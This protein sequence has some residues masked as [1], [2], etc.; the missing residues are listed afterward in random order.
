MLRVQMS[1][2]VKGECFKEAE[3]RTAEFGVVTVTPCNAAIKN[4]QKRI[5]SNPPPQWI[6]SRVRCG[7]RSQAGLGLG[8]AE[9]GKHRVDE[10]ESL[11]D[12]LADFGAR[13]DDLA[14][15]ED[16]E[17]DLWLHHTV[18][19][20]GEQLRLV[21]AES[22]MR[23]SQALETDRETNVGA[24]NNVLMKGQYPHS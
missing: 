3:E 20:T 16:E 1:S 19:Q 24:A 13:Q 7:C 10:L 12:L 9:V 21:R 2:R 17:D 6:R 23:R 22:V 11:V 14:A 15:H 18:D 4:S 5:V 8:L